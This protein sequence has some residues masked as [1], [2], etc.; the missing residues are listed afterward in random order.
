MPYVV[1]VGRTQKCKVLSW[2]WKILIWH[3]IVDL[4]LFGNGIY[5]WQVRRLAF[6]LHVLHENLALLFAK[7]AL[8]G[9]HGLAVANALVAPS[10]VPDGLVDLGDI[11]HPR[12]EVL[13]LVPD[14]PEQS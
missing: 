12:V 3:S 9:V 10:V 5:G 13:S 14:D 11:A 7:P 4:H 8:D 1:P 2:F 6:L